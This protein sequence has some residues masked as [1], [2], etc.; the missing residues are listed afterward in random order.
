MNNMSESSMSNRGRELLQ[1]IESRPALV[2]QLNVIA[3][4]ISRLQHLINSQRHIDNSAYEQQI[5]N[6]KAQYAEIEAQL[7]Q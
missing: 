5:V 2:A 6:L 7:D 1:P 3:E 4:Q